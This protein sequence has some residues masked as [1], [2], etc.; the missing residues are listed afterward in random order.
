MMKSVR[1]T[2][3]KSATKKP[4][5]PAPRISQAKSQEIIAEVLKKPTKSKR[6][7][8]TTAKLRTKPKTKKQVSVKNRL[9]V[10]NEEAEA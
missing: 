4:V 6:S 1:A 10:I 5:H 7:A 8:S 2:H 9:P 3:K